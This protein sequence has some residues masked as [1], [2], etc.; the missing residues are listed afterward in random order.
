[1]TT[2]LN[3]NRI[4]AKPR[5]YQLEARSRQIQLLQKYN[6]YLQL[7]DCGIGKTYMQ[8][9]LF[10]KNVDRLPILIICPSQA[11]SVWVNQISD[12]AK[13]SYNVVNV[14]NNPQSQKKILKQLKDAEIVIINYEILGK[15]EYYLKKKNFKIL[16]MDEAH[17][18]QNRKSIR[19]KMTKKVSIGIKYKV[20]I[21]ATPVDG[22]VENLFPILDIINPDLI[23]YRQFINRFGVPSTGFNGEIEY[24]KCSDTKALHEF[25]SPY[26]IRYMKKDVA[27]E[28]PPIVTTTIPFDITNRKEYL[29]A[30]KGLLKFKNGVYETCKD[31]VGV[32]NRLTQL[33]LITSEGKIK[34]GI[35]WIKN[36][37]ASG[38]KLVVMCYYTNSVNKIEKQFKDV[39]VRYDGSVSEKNKAI[40]EDRFNNDD[41][42]RLFVAHIDSAKESISLNKSCSHLAFFDLSYSGIA[43]SQSL[44]RIHRINNR[45]DIPVN[46]YFFLATGT[47]DEKVV[48]AHNRKLTMLTEIMDNKKPNYQDIIN[49][50]K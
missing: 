50:I 14:R 13:E 42:C 7:S 40:A 20:A 12:F 19:T 31:K 34:D 43:N 49:Y 26:V 44:Q 29:E 27:K 47:I 23:K 17:K 10:T 15:W 6:C 28:L 39:C 3:Q 35:E 21:T 5:K 45:L 1:M 25:I 33:R 32:L 24:K 41:S 36:H 4:D 38:E 37:L 9:M 11:K 46:I 48:A 8:I 18:L 2:K 22:K 16:F 30:S